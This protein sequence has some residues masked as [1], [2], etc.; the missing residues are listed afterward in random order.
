MPQDDDDRPKTGPLMLV[1]PDD[2]L[3]T[4][5]RLPGVSAAL[6]AAMIHKIIGGYFEAVG[7][8]YRGDQWIAYTVEGLRDTP[9]AQPNLA[10]DAMIRAMGV[11]PIAVMLGPVI[12]LGRDG[13]AEIDVPESL[14][15]L[16]R[17]AGV[18]A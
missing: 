13:S 16:A 2:G 15:G 3:A 18:L 14:L 7:G 6:D 5:E 9:H 12:F 10:A 1:V 17:S 11:V 8:A 4:A